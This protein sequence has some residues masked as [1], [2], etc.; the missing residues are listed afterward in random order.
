VVNRL[1]TRK[2]QGA[3]LAS[4]L[5]I[6]INIAGTGA[7]H[8]GLISVND[9]V[10][11]ANSITLDTDSGLEWLD[12]TV[13]QNRS[14]AD[15][16]NQ[17]GSGG[18]FQ[19]W[20]HATINDLVTLQT[21]A[22]FAP[23]YDQQP[24]TTEFTNLIDTL[25]RTQDG[26]GFNNVLT[27]VGAV[28]WF[29]DGGSATGTSHLRFFELNGNNAQVLAE[30][31]DIRS[32]NNFNV[33]TGNWLVKESPSNGPSRKGALQGYSID[34][35]GNPVIGALDTN[36]PSIVLTHGWQP[37][38][39]F[40]TDPFAL[41]GTELAIQE[42]LASKGLSANIL[43]YSW[44]DAYQGVAHNAK[45]ATNYHG[46]VLADAIELALPEYSQG[47]HIIGHSYGSLLN[48]HAVENLDASYKIDQF[49]ILDAPNSVRL[50]LGTGLIGGSAGINY[51]QFEELLDPAK[52]EYVD[53]YYSKNL[54]GSSL[55]DPP[56]F[57]ASL[58]GA[59][60]SGGVDVNSFYETGG[61]GIGHSGV[62]NTFYSDWITSTSD[63]H[64]GT[65]GF[66]NQYGD[67]VTAVDTATFDNRSA[68]QTW[69]HGPGLL[70]S[71]L[72][73]G[74]SLGANAW[75]TV[76]GT[77][78][79]ALSHGACGF[80]PA[81]TGL[82]L[83]EAS[84]SAMSYA[85]EVPIVAE[86]FSFDFG[87]SNIGDGDWL[88]LHFEDELLWTFT[89]DGFSGNDLFDALISVDH[90]AGLS[91][92]FYFTL[93]SVGS[94]NAQIYLNNFEFL[95]ASSAVSEPGTVAIISLF[96][97]SLVHARRKLAA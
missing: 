92:T 5:G 56:G 68:P 11:G 84:P 2:I 55:S 29:D 17:F 85:T 36:L 23:P 96:L 67:W 3:F 38:G 10:F 60:P 48:A 28:G 30:T 20:R 22:G 44:E 12:L 6:G 53:N 65:V 19:G 13:T 74:A 51:N 54:L 64:Q 33:D 87:F 37:L 72:S 90:L 32:I 15:V 57:G 40:D 79:E 83:I 27:G 46:Q 8:S 50:L 86:L 93:H 69:S 58:D 89:G 81:P 94:A 4:I 73:L 16:A 9:G 75:N 43:T 35:G 1:I 71:V 62:H 52:V 63:A 47:I 95:G 26:V 25:G 76:T 80:G 42:E 66:R 18:E 82:C 34:G 31:T 21:N 70:S 91:G 77:V 39:D 45:A 14:Y 78:I 24:I 59:A 97:V 7:S 49:T 41:R 61:P 88:T